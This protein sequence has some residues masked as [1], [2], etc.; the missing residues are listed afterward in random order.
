MHVVLGISRNKSGR[1]THV[2]S[3]ASPAIMPA[4]RELVGEMIVARIPAFDREQWVQAKLQ[5]VESAGIWIETVAL[6]NYC[7]KARGTSIAEG[8]YVMFVPFAQI[9]AIVS[10][11]PGI[12]LSD[13]ALGA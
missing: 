13:E 7:L 9:L 12:S 10:M 3:D 11:A 8:T 2:K 1:A 6:T 4:L 5:G